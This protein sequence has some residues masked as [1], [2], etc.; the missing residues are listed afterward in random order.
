M[1]DDDEPL[2]FSSLSLATGRALKALAKQ[3]VTDGD[4]TDDAK[5][6]DE[7]KEVH[8]LTRGL[9]RDLSSI[10]HSEPLHHQVSSDGNGNPEQDRDRTESER[11]RD[12]GNRVFDRSRVDSVCHGV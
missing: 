1:Q 3:Q 8:Q 5:R 7:Q 2:T 10:E 12:F 6:D 4:P 11:N 9:Y